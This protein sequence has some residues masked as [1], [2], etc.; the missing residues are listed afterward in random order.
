MCN[1]TYLS[2]VERT[3]P[4]PRSK[5]PLAL[6]ISIIQLPRELTWK[7]VL[8]NT[9]RLILSAAG[10]TGTK[11]HPW[12]IIVFITTNILFNTNWFLKK[13]SPTLFKKLLWFIWLSGLHL[14][15]N[16][17]WNMAYLVVVLNILLLTWGSQK[18][19]PDCKMTTQNVHCY[20]TM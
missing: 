9:F 17:E 11:K 8:G 13:S 18:Y 7:L 3:E 1:K 20:Q 10:S 16:P 12:P 2:K 14:K 15:K 4:S 19:T 5:L 6:F